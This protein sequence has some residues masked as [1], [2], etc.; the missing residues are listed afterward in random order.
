[1]RQTCAKS[2]HKKARNSSL[3]M[4]T[5]APAK[6][7]SRAKEQGKSPIKVIIDTDPGIDDAFAVLM[8]LSCAP[9]LQVLALTSSFGNV[10]TEKATENCKKLLR[11]YKSS[12]SRKGSEDEKGD[13]KD[14]VVYVAE[15][16]KKA[17][18]GKQKEHIADFVHGEDG[19]GD[20]E[21]DKEE[22]S[23]E[24]E[25]VEV[26]P[27]GSAKLMYDLAKTYPGEVTI[28]CLATATNVVNAFREY[29]DLPKLLRS[30]VHLGGAYTV[31]GNVN[32]AAEANVYADA[33][34]ADELYGTHGVD[35]YAVGLDVTMNVRMTEENLIKMRDTKYVKGRETLTDEERQFLFNS[36]QFYM[37]Y[38]I[39]SLNFRGVLQHDS[40]CVMT[41]IHPEMFEWTRARV[42]VA[43]ESFARGMVI[44]DK[45]GEKNWS[46]ENA[47][48]E[49][50][51][52]NVALTADF[53]AIEKA[54]MERFI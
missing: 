41:V 35:I 44:M 4:T 40:V 7:D 46:F 25:D 26:Y 10:R 12:G 13:E 8:S 30:V 33:E 3:E 49:R 17:L 42:R 19:F 6:A 24:K 29:E 27:G 9:E 28:V 5:N 18:N 1:M 54:L 37:N 38:H 36:S 22:L 14:D 39:K 32:P 15:G 52:M 2:L 34:A 31:S 45:E 48:T 51:L 50:P 23:E 20:F 43:T 47:W 21:K 11:I 16:S 53:E